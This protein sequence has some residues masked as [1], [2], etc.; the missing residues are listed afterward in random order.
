MKTS[1]TKSVEFEPDTY[2][3]VVFTVTATDEIVFAEDG[4]T[5]DEISRLE[6]RVDNGDF[7]DDAYDAMSTAQHE[8]E[9]PEPDYE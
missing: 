6:E 8:Q 9:P 5:K 1:F 7:D 4:L 2:K 3:D